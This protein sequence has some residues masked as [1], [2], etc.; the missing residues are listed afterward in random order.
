MRRICVHV[1][2]CSGSLDGAEIR[3]WHLDEPTDGLV[4]DPAAQIVLRGWAAAPLGTPIYLVLKYHQQTRSYP[5]S[6]PRQDVVE[7]FA[8]AQPRLALPLRCGFRQELSVAELVAGVRLGFETRGRITWVSL[9]TA[10]V[11]D[12][13]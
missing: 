11:A 2:A 3:D 7:H 5:F 10:L 12:L 13:N 8:V 6:E 1:T 4:T 9:I